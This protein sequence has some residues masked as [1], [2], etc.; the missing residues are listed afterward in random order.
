MND[1]TDEK[2]LLHLLENKDKRLEHTQ[3][4]RQDS[5]IK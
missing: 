2:Y 3:T 4:H 1:L 5:S